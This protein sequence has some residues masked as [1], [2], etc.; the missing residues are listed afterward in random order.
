M[1]GNNLQS[2]LNRFQQFIVK[3]SSPPATEPPYHYR[4]LADALGG[5]LVTTPAGAYCR[6]TSRYSF[7]YRHGNFSL[8]DVMPKAS[9]PLSAFTKD[10]CEEKIEPASLLCLD[11]ETTGLGG[12]GTVAFLVGCGFLVEDGFVIRQYLIPDYSDEAAMLEALMADFASQPV[13]VSYNGKA[14]DLPLLLDRMIIN[15]VTREL[16]TRH[17][18][19]L[20]HPVRRLF[21]R[22]LGDCSL[23]NVEQELFAFRR[24]ND[25]P[26]YL[27]PSV[28]FD[29]LAER[30][31]EFLPAVV[32]H[33]R[34]DILTLFFL[35]FFLARIFRT[36]G[37]TLEAVEDL[38]SLSRIYGLRKA[39]E[40]AVGLYERMRSQVQEP[41][42]PEVLLFHADIFKKIGA[43]EKAVELWES[44][45]DS[46]S[47]EGF[48]ASLELAKY[49]EHKAKNIPHAYHYA[50]LAQKRAPSASSHHRQLRHRL[51]R[52]RR[53][54]GRS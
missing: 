17:H 3:E 25:I 9:L 22:R 12:A 14:F 49:F 7:S 24:P 10:H 43:Y 4:Q 35:V 13:V 44:L 40:Q 37:E 53:K 50:R 6:I 2:K 33:N 1:S 45:A 36:K 26:G 16:P 5:E 54:M 30:R 34:W 20:L 32:S 41:L 19:D 48:R 52:L 31:T 27:I 42:A 23:S 21:R 39:N 15:R 38:Y 18:L 47:R 8:Q 28:Y 46:D 51:A 11:T 29:W